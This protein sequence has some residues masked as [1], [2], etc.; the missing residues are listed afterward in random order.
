MS[1]RRVDL[2]PAELC[3][4]ARPT[5]ISTVL[6]SCVAICLLGERPGTAAMCHSMLPSGRV[7]RGVEVG[8][9]V[10]EALEAMLFGLRRLGVKPDQVQAK[11]F[12]GSDMFGLEGGELCR[13]TVGRQNI[14]MARMLLATSNIPL[15]AENTGGSMGRKICF[16]TGSGEVHLKWLG[17]QGLKAAA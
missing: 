1:H 6:G 17:Q 11:L 8:R 3:V 5:V 7:G 14:E 16:H 9:F 10:D 13:L 12:G 2:K 15:V 4:V